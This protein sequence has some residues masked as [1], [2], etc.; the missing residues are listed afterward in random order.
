MLL[1]RKENRTIN[2]RRKLREVLRCPLRTVRAFLLKEAFQCFWAYKSATWA[3]W[4][5]DKWCTRAMRSRLEPMKRIA[6]MLR[7]HRA[8]LLNWFKAKGEI[9]LGVV[10]GL[11]GNAK[12]A[13][14]KARGFRTYEALGRALSSAWRPP[15]A[16]MRPQILLTRQELLALLG[17]ADVFT[18][19]AEPLTAATLIGQA[20]SARVPLAIINTAFLGE[21]PRLCSW[22]AQL[23]GS[24]NRELASS[25][26]SV[27]QTVFVLDGADLFLPAGAGKAPSKNPV[28]DLLKRAGP[29]GLGLVLASQR[30]GELDYRRCTEID[31][32]FVGK[33]DEQTLDK[34]KLL[35]EHRP[36]GHR[37]PS[38]LESGRLVML[39]DSGA[40]DVE[41]SSPLIRLE[42]LEGLELK[43]L[44]ARTHPRAREAPPA[45]R[46]DA[47]E[48]DL[49][50]RQHQPR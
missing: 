15:R 18:P 36:L 41:R 22:V 38:R 26:S 24:V 28:Q 34:M 21:G 43:N 47:A 20:S 50:L 29:A 14:R 39:H 5:L 23:I 49:S 45:R 31:T 12:L 11:N 44:A 33:T 19:G 46:A 10:E 6:K 1:K 8:L 32:W 40:R 25:T 7:S 42:R 2:Q 37:N 48:D 27:L 17:N 16:A 13:I 3:G 35:F 4:F 30:P 9:A